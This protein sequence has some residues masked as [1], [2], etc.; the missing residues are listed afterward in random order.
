MT[1][2]PTNQDPCE[3]GCT[4]DTPINEPWTLPVVSRS[5]EPLRE[6]GVTGC[7]HCRELYEYWESDPDPVPGG[8][9]RLPNSSYTKG[10]T[11]GNQH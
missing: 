11:N 7:T 9:D 5:P 4:C 6:C 1:W 8:G 2:K 3:P 10:T